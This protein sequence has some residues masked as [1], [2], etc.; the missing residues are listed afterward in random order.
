MEYKSPYSIVNVHLNLIMIALHDL[1]NILLYKDSSIS[2]HPQ[3]FDMFTL[4]YQ[5]YF[6]NISYEKMICHVTTTM[7]IDL[8]NHE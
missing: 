6:S 7:K 4:F 1:L 3:W 5:T 8:K 2:I